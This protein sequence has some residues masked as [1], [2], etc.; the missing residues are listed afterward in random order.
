MPLMQ[1][2]VPDSAPGQV[3]AHTGQPFP[4]QDYDVAVLGAGRMGTA[5]ALFLRQLVPTRSLLLVEEGGLPNE[6]GATLLSPGVWTTLDVPESH[7]PEAH[8]TRTQLSA[9]T[10]DIS[11]QPRPMI[12]LH[13]TAGGARI[14]SRDLTLDPEVVDVAALPWA[15]V[16]TRAAT[17]R[18]GALALA[19]A[20]AAIRAG[21]DLLLN[22]RAHLGGDGRVVLERLTVTNTH[23]IVVHET[24][25]VRAGTIVVALGAHG[26]HA[27]EHDLG[28]HTAHARAY[29]QA[30]RVNWPSTDASP[31]LRAGGVTLRPQHGGYVLVPAIHHRDPAGYVP[32]GGRLT[33]VPT[34]LRRET[35]EDLVAA[36]DVLPVLG[37]EA[38]ES[39]RSVSDVPGAWLALPGGT[40]AGLPQH[41]QV[42]PGVH[43]LLG[44]PHADTLG[45]ST[46]YD[47]AA[48]IAGV[49]ERPWD[50]PR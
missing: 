4:S 5:C 9:D 40:P 41:E 36:L 2:P 18:P 28:T 26:S 45:L 47:L 44:G 21:A 33:G 37:T 31:V 17:Y 19:A 38:L 49:A 20:Q 27:A 42:A 50:R 22:T 46:A 15:T 11:F 8:W 14:P 34:G 29:R 10:W 1:R 32:T 39:G 30:P 7:W 23:Q 24:H 48:T 25:H 3:W 12:D 16:D 35:L 13:A 6:D 43:L